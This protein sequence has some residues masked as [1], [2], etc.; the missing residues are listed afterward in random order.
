MLLRVFSANRKSLLLLLFAASL[1]IG[2]LEGLFILIAKSAVSGSR[3]QTWGIPLIGL[4]LIVTARTLAQIAAA[5]LELGGVSVWL[6]GLRQGL[7]RATADRAFPAYREPWR[8]TV[9]TALEDGMEDLSQGIGAGFRCLAAAAHILV[10]APLL[11]VFSWKLAAGALALAAPAL[12]ASRLRAR[13]LSAS[14]RRWSDSKAALALEAETFAEGLESHA[15]NGRL[16]QA[17]SRL[18]AGLDRH[19][20]RARSWETAKAVFPPALEWLFFMALAGLALL[21]SV[22]GG[23]DVGAS[24]SW[25]GPLGL[26]PFGALLLLLYRPIR[27]WARNYPVYLMGSQAWLSLQR[28]Q[29]ELD[30]FPLREPRPDSPGGSIRLEGLRFGYAPGRDRLVIDGMDLDLDPAELT[31]I[32]GR[33]GAGKSTLL[34]L[35]SGIEHPS[36]GRILMPSGAREPAFAYL[37]Q[38]AFLEPDWGEWEAGFRTRRPADWRDLDAILG[39][40]AILEKNLEKNGGDSGS[41]FR[42]RPKSLSG[43]E[44]QRLCLARVFASEARYLLLDE[45]TTWLAAGDRERILGDLLAFWRRPDALGLRRGAALVSHE[46]FIGGFCSRTVDIEA[47]AQLA[48]EGMAAWGARV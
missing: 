47:K 43:G 35:L 16:E 11:F 48:L 10:L 40:A 19:A 45:P 44:R 30:G 18:G 29:A 37:P 46:P 17:A 31:W 22:W 41:A 36:G 33:N 21:G 26:L 20:E 23:G 28:L 15:G 3:W 39:L 24:A 4:A 9:V 8:N 32:S 2:I 1:A 38:K 14:G 13:V 27:E 42:P 25:S 5:R 12:L 7:L 6:R 34:K